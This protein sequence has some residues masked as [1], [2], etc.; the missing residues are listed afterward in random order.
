M[1]NVFDCHLCDTKKTTFDILASAREGKIENHKDAHN[2]TSYGIVHEICKCNSCQGFFYRKRQTEKENHFLMA[3][4]YPHKTTDAS[5]AGILALLPVANTRLSPAIDRF[6]QKY[7]T[8]AVNCL[9]VE[10]YDAASIMF[11]KCVYR[12]CNEQ[13]VPLTVQDNG[14]ERKL[15]GKERIQKLGLPKPLNDVLCGID[16]LGGDAAH[17]DEEPYSPKT[18]QQLKG[19]LLVVFRL[20]YEDKEMLKNFTEQYSQETQQRKNGTKK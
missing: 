15:S 3:G 5:G 12:I 13:G 7:F 1:E 8:E 18:L 6:I 17:E 4:Q 2:F 16:G 10:A 9:S 19:A 14:K 20:L 11:R